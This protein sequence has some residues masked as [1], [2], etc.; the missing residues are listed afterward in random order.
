[1]A[2]NYWMFVESPENFAISRDL[3]FTLH[4]LGPKYRKRA[5]RMRPEDRVVFY[6]SGLRK[7]VAT[8]TITSRYFEDKTPIWK[9]VSRNGDLPYRVKLAPDIVVDEADYI[10]A[11]ILAPRLEYVKRWAPE[12]WPLA[13]FDRLHLLPQRDFRLIE[14]EMKRVVNKGGRRGR[15]RW[16]DRVDRPGAVATAANDDLHAADDLI[17]GPEALSDAPE[18]AAIY[19]ATEETSP[20]HGWRSTPPPDADGSPGMPTAEERPGSPIGD[21]EVVIEDELSPADVRAPAS[22]T[23]G[24]IESSVT[25]TGETQPGSPADNPEHMVIEASEPE[26]A[27]H[28]APQTDTDVSDV[29]P[30]AAEAPLRPPN[31]DPERPQE[32]DRS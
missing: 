20:T 9:S 24:D 29:T 12:D 19:D 30:R 23:T 6:V 17:D 13:F 32:N 8:A 28:Q 11:L 22:E 5:E 14:G 27:T 18:P 31:G 16:N 15:R 4:G 25:S 2:K 10:D 7:W 3:G 1:M 26:G 21:P